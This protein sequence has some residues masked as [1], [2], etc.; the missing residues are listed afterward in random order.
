MIVTCI[1]SAVVFVAEI[2]LVA[3]RERARSAVVMDGLLNMEEPSAMAAVW[4][5]DDALSGQVLA[6]LKKLHEVCG[7]QILDQHGTVRASLTCDPGHQNLSARIGNL[8]LGSTV[9]DYRLLRHTDSLSQMAV[10][11]EIRIQLDPQ[12]AGDDFVAYLVTTLIGNILRALLLGIILAWSVHRYLALPIITLSRKVRE[13]DPDRPLTN[14]IAALP[15]H[16]ADELGQLISGINDTLALLHQSREDLLH[17]ARHDALVDLPNRKGLADWLHRRIADSPRKAALFLLDLDGFKHVNDSLGHRFGDL[18]LWEVGK[19]LQ[20]SV[21]ES[22]LVGRLGGD[23]FVVILD[24]FA[25]PQQLAA[26]TV[27]LIQA[28]GRLFDLEGRPVH[29]S[30]AIGVAIYPDD[31]ADFSALLRAADAAMHT[32]KAEGPGRY[33]FFSQDMT[34]RARRRLGLEENLR[35]AVEYGRFELHYQPKVRVAD[36]GL[37]GVEALLR[38]HHEG[39]LVD[40]ASFIPVAEESGLIVPI[41]NW[42]LEHACATLGRWHRRFQPAAIAIN[43]SARDFVDPLLPRR[44]ADT[45]S[46]YDVQPHLLEVEI[47]ET[48]LMRE[49]E[50]CAGTL[51]QLREIGVRIAVDDFGTGY[52]SLAY[53]RRLPIDVLKIDRAFVQGVPADPMI[54]STII[55]L[56]KKMGMLTVAE[57]VETESQRDWL[58]NEQCDLMQ[59]W[60]ISRAIPKAELERRFMRPSGPAWAGSYNAES[61]G[62]YS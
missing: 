55:A 15:D 16:R 26:T 7:A 21:Q 10:I 39:R 40:P 22:D 56:G 8:L 54:A 50:R 5:L 23:E 35:R 30:T 47:T 31:G 19:R 41:S 36:R 27:R 13:V 46:A 61:N 20:A 24:G 12:A 57:G 49:V 44:V 53:L 33:R 45:L 43:F 38:W 17:Q 59:G 2:S 18:L 51:A 58:L 62:E 3:I 34:E 29:A 48:S 52:S 42:V 9:D 28:I 37:T 25:N 32:A 1:L 14:L 4:N 11:G 60:L 6:G